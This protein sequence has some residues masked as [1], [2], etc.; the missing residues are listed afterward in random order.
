R[1]VSSFAGY[2]GSVLLLQTLRFGASIVC[3]RIAGPAEWGFWTLLNTVLA[4]SYIADFGVVNGMNRD[5]ALF[6]GRG[7]RARV[8]T[9]ANTSKSLVLC[10]SALCTL[11]AA[12]F[13][14]TI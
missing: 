9:I 2:G 6:R 14:F 5:I 10:T 8:T 13:A 12:A 3:A 7:D 1:S 11:A 4:Y